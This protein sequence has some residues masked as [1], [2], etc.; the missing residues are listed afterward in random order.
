M[1]TL[2]CAALSRFKGRMAAALRE[3]FDRA[4][5]SSAGAIITLVPEGDAR[6]RPDPYRTALSAPDGSFTLRCIVPGDYRLFGGMTL[7]PTH[8]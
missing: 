4:N 6:L 5:M 3:R 1:A 8:T 2:Q 7:S